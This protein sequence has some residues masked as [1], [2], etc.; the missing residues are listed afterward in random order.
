MSA[1]GTLYDETIQNGF[2]K[3]LSTTVIANGA[4]SAGFVLPAAHDSYL[5]DLDA[6]YM[7]TDGAALLA[8]VSNNNGASYAADN[9]WWSATTIWSNA[10]NPSFSQYGSAVLGGGH[11][12][13]LWLSHG[14][15]L[16]HSAMG[17][18]RVY[19]HVNVGNVLW[20]TGTL[21]PTNYNACHIG[22]GFW[23]SAG[24]VNAIQF[25]PH[26]G[27]F[28]GGTIRLFGLKKGT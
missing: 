13:W 20:K 2:A 18:V 27:V 22:S 3:L 4:G 28:T 1:V 15:W 23:A 14:N 17:R 26:V 9:Y 10:V 12:T 25:L 8:R 5:L 24:G 6:I 11:T 7:N 16:G 21:Q 19:P